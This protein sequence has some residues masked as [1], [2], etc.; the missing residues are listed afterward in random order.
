M[1]DIL[2]Q[3]AVCGLHGSGWDGRTAHCHC[4]HVRSYRGYDHATA[5]DLRGS[6][7]AHAACVCTGSP[8]RVDINNNEE[9]CVCVLDAYIPCSTSG[10]EFYSSRV[11]ILAFR[12][13]LVG[14]DE[15]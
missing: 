4:A 7:P 3:H 12:R 5:N 9:D 11:C 14:R 2:L 10:V 1:R 13:L 8:R 15:V 6:D